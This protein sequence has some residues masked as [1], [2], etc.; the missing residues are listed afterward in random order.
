LAFAAFAIGA[1]FHRLARGAAWL[2]AAAVTLAFLK[3][4]IHDY[5]D[6]RNEWFNQQNDWSGGEYPKPRSTRS[7]K[8]VISI[9]GLSS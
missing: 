4:R 9:R 7:S 8:A 3:K 2:P 1:D 5:S 6:Y